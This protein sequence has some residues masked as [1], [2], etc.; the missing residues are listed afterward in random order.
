MGLAIARLLCMALVIV[1]IIR[2]A[3]SGR[4]N[5]THE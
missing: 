3:T 2:V 5:P 1:A 4:D